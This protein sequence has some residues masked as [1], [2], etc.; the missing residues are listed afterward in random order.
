MILPPSIAVVEVTDALVGV[1]IDG[2]VFI[3]DPLAATFVL[4]APPPPTTI[5]PA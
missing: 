5:F 3:P 1:E 4:V 2:K